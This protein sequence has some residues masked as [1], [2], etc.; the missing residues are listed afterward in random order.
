MGSAKQLEQLTWLTARAR[1]SVLGV[2]TLPVG[3]MS[4]QKEEKGG[5]NARIAKAKLHRH[6][7]GHLQMLREIQR[8]DRG[9]V[10]WS[11]AGVLCTMHPREEG[12]STDP[13][14]SRSSNHGS[15]RPHTKCMGPVFTIA[16]LAGQA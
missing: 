6:G 11:Y 9:P 7:D 5:E 12:A 3:I 1:C 8:G 10:M 13:L 4:A 15:H 2:T 14:A 16:V